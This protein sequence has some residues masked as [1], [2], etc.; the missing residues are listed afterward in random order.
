MLKVEELSKSFGDR[1]ILDCINLKLDRGEIVFVLG[2]SGTGKSVLLKCLVGLLPADSGKIWIDG[3]NVAHFSESQFFHIRRKC[4]LIFQK[5]AL[6]DF[7]NVRENVLFGLNR[8]TEQSPEANLQLAR[9]ALQQVQMSGFEERHPATL[10]FGEQ[11]RVS[12]ARALALQPQVLLFDEPTTGLDPALSFSINQLIQKVARE[13]KTAT[14]VVSHDMDCALD[15]ADRIIVLHRGRI[16][17]QGSPGE[18]LNSSQEL[19][20]AFLS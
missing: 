9:W 6:F 18:I 10:S 13:S 20:Q 12:L 8:L 17:D 16:L 2:Q 14:L 1:S 7:L 19:V 5:P 3:E 11:K 4:G 15:I